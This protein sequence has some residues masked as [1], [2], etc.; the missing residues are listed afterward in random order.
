M[1][2]VILQLVGQVELPPAMDHKPRWY[3]GYFLDIV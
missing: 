3:Q 2:S 1:A